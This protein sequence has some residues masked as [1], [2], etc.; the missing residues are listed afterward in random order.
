[1]YG[2]RKLSVILGH[3]INRYTPV[4]KQMPINERSSCKQPPKNIPYKIC[5][6]VVHHSEGG[7]VTV[8][9]DPI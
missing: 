5:Q 2:N 4:D 3:C 9:W 6:Y 1:M 8:L 7:V